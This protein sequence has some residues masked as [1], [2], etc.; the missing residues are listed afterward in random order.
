[1][2][3]TTLNEN[4]TDEHKDGGNIFSLQVSTKD[5]QS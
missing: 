1:M 3:I 4:E 2:N 5:V